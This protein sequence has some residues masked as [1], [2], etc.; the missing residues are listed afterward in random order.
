VR[1]RSA[2]TEGVPGPAAHPG[3]PLV[4]EGEVL[5]DDPQQ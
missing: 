5:R 4:I 3:R 2:R 1:V